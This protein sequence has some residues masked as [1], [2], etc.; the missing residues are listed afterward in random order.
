[1]Q[2]PTKT[3]LVIALCVALVGY[4]FFYGFLKRKFESLSKNTIHRICTGLALLLVYMPFLLDPNLAIYGKLSVAGIGFLFWV[5]GCI[6]YY[7]V[8][9]KEQS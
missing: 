1:M 7:P 3:L 5:I 6:L 9:R 2:Y 8:K 4:Y